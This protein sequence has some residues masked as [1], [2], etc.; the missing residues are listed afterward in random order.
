MTEESEPMPE[1]PR[2]I[3]AAKV[4]FSHASDSIDKMVWRNE[5]GKRAM[6]AL[7]GFGVFASLG[8]QVVYGQAGLSKQNGGHQQNA[9]TQQYII[10]ILQG[11]S[12]TIGIEDDTLNQIKSLAK[13]IESLTSPAAVEKNNKE[14]KA[15][16]SQVVLCIEN[17]EDR[18]AQVGR[19]ETPGPVLAGCPTQ[20][21]AAGAP[22]KTVTHT[23]KHHR[24]KRS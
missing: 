8:L 5:W 2:Q 11:H 7:V 13:Q 1:T 4:R 24:K 23:P 16:I 10:H 12:K 3:E 21:P 19:G 17:H 20:I 15:V 9:A 22:H 6:V 18:D 14:I